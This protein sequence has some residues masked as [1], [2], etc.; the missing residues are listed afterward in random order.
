M[1]FS[2]TVPA[3]LDQ[4]CLLSHLPKELVAYLK[5]ASLGS[6]SRGKH[7]KARTGTAKLTQQHH[8]LPI[9]VDKAQRQ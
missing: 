3:D 1:S 9:L 6:T 7:I 2:V 5:H 8:G 4:L